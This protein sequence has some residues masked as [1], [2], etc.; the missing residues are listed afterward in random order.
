VQPGSSSQLD[1][2][3]G[4]LNLVGDFALETLIRDGLSEI[5]E[6]TTKPAIAHLTEFSIHGT[7]LPSRYSS[8]T[9]PGQGMQCP[10]LAI[11]AQG[12]KQIMLGNEAFTYD[13][14]HYLVVSLDLPVSGRVTTASKA[15][16]FLGMRL[17]L[18][19]KQIPSLRTSGKIQRATKSDRGVFVS[20]TTPELLDAVLRLLRLLGKPEDSAVL[21]PLLHRDLSPR[22]ISGAS[23]LKDSPCLGCCGVLRSDSCRS[24]LR[25]MP[26]ARQMRLRPLDAANRQM[27]S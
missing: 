18:D 11:V 3:R 8:P 5:R 9:Q 24:A 25:M 6:L 4:V 21:A 12:T 23:A 27:Q 7:T 14:G 17:D 13:P 15:K 2:V 22:A 19:V 16:P 10:T 26:M 20:R 1:G